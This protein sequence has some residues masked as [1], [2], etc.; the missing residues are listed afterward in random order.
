MPSCDDGSMPEDYAVKELL[1]NTKEGLARMG[2][3]AAA[4]LTVDDK[5]RSAGFINITRRVFKL[6]VGPWPRDKSQRFLGVFWR[7]IIM[8]GLQGLAMGT[9]GRGLKWS[10][11]EIE[12]Y[13]VGVRKA[14][15][16]PEIHTYWPYHIITA[17]KPPRE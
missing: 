16:D 14:L 8:E 15:M 3:D 13:L 2:R 1:T 6:P 12:L 11:D 9:L 10:P 5:L 17:Q 4:I 7:T